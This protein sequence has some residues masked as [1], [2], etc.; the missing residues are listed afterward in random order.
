MERLAGWGMFAPRARTLGLLIRRASTLMLACERIVQIGLLFG[1][2]RLSCTE[3]Y[4]L[5]RG[6][7]G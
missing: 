3:G 1:W 5:L 6:W 2:G 7:D 4:I